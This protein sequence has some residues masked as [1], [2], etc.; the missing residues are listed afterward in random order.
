MTFHNLFAKQA[1]QLEKEAAKQDRRQKH[2]AFIIGAFATSS[3]A[4]LSLLGGVLTITGHIA[5]GAAM[6][7][8]G[9]GASM[10]TVTMMKDAKEK[11]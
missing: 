10:G 2:Q 3:F 7:T 4:G 9:M 6:S 5:E 11:Q 1:K 8:T